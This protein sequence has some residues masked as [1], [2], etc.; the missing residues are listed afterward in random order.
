LIKALQQQNIAVSEHCDGL[1]VWIK[2]D[3]DEKELVLALAK[4]GW[5]VRAGSVFSSLKNAPALRVTVT[6]LKADIAQRFA[7]DLGN[8]LSQLK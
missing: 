4:R 3:V 6:K 5:L 8:A 1:N 7:K 2:L